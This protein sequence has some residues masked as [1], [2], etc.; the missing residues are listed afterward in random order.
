GVHELVA[1]VA[2]DSPD[3][4]AVVCAGA[5]VT[6]GELW[7]PA[8]RLAGYLRGA[9]VRPES[10]VGVCLERG[11]DLVVALLGTWLAGA[12]YLPLDPGYPVARLTGLVADSGAGLVVC[13]AA[14]AERLA[15]SGATVVRLDDPR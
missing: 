10:V 6:Y 13:Q 9:G 14:G 4:V 12:A 7:G 11:V 15:G 5:S 3:A 1:R 2:A 8:G